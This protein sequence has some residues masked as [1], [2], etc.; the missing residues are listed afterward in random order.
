MGASRSR[1]ECEQKSA[2]GHANDS[3]GEIQ[4]VKLFCNFQ[5]IQC[6]GRILLVRK[7][8]WR[9]IIGELIEYPL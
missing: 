5:G 2:P 8:K 4:K 1:N 7:D 9:S 6:V 3:I